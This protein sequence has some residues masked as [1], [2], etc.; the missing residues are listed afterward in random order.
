M[1]KLLLVSIFITF[2]IILPIQTMARVDINAGIS[3]PPPI[4]FVALPEAIT[5]PDTSGVYVF[6]DADMPQ[7]DSAG[8]DEKQGEKPLEKRK[9][10]GSEN[11]S[12]WKLNVWPIK[13]P[14][15]VQSPHEMKEENKHIPPDR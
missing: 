6:A 9:T 2:T 10:T 4:L 11:K 8:R 3:M 14:D 5:L 13:S 12:D 7:G 15:N 1:K